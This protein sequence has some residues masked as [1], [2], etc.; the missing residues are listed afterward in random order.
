MKIEN[1]FALLHSS[2][3]NLLWVAFDFLKRKREIICQMPDPPTCLSCVCL[4]FFHILGGPGS[5]LFPPFLSPL[6][7]APETPSRDLGYRLGVMRTAV[8]ALGVG[9]VLETERGLGLLKNQ[10]LKLLT[11]V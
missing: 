9:V 10:G 2:K 1:Y 8:S 4:M 11:T 3:F 6:T 7:Q 5:S